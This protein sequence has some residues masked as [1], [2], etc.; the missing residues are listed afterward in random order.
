MPFSQASNHVDTETFTTETAVPVREGVTDIELGMTNFRTVSRGRGSWDNRWR[1]HERDSFRMYEW[2]FD[3]AMGVLPDTEVRVSTGWVDIS[4]REARYGVR[5]RGRGMDDLRVAVKRRLLDDRGISIA[6]NP[7]L[8]IP[9][10]R[11]TDI[12]KNRLGPGQNYW[13]IE[14]KFILTQEYE[15]YAYN[16]DI[17][18][19]LPFGNTRRD[20]VRD[21]GVH[22]QSIDPDA[23]EVGHFTY[24]FASIYTGDLLDFDVVAFR[25]VFETNYLHAWRSGGSGSDLLLATLGCIALIDENLTD[26]DLRAKFAYQQ[27]VAGRN[28]TNAYRI[29][30]SAAYSF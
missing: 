17:G 8:T 4:D 10:G 7:E 12:D 6:F 21:L 16:L 19:S 30:L 27:P 26:G 15:N 13:S 25:P 29:L 22:T 5:T 3:A 14:P 28:V 18:Y 9:I 20:Y 24:N 1:R 23:K 2:T 11:E